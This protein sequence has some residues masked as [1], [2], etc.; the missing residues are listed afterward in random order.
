MNTQSGEVFFLETPTAYM[1]DVI[2]AEK[3]TKARIAFIELKSYIYNKAK[4]LK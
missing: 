1:E 4:G 2:L 3:V